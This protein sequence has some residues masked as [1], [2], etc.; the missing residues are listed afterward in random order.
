MGEVFRPWYNDI[1]NSYGNGSE[2]GAQIQ[3]LLMNIMRTLK[4]RG[5]NPVQILLNS[6]KSYVRSGKLAPLPTKITANG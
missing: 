6:L 2:R 5:H 1:L 4:M 3:L